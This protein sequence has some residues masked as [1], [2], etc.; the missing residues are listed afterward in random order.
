MSTGSLTSGKKYQRDLL[1]LCEILEGGDPDTLRCL[2]KEYSTRRRHRGAHIWTIGAIFIP[3]SVSGAA[4]LNPGIPG[5]TPAMALV[6]I[7]LIWVWFYISDTLR[8]RIDSILTVCAAL[9][10]VMLRRESPLE[11]RGLEGLHR[12]QGLTLGRLRVVIAVAITTVWGIVA[13]VDF[14]C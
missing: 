1:Q 4:V 12:E 14:L 6:S 2:Y 10:T 3:L 7:A 5:R 11:I 9:E 13:A 8:H